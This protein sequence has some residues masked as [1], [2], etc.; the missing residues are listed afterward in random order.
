M[1]RLLKFAAALL[2]AVSIAAELGWIKIYHPRLED[3]HQ[4]LFK[5]IKMILYLFF[6]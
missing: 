3:V 4:L 5:G 1:V 2:I 6:S